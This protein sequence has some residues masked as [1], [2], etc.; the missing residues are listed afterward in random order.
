[1]DRC[2]HTVRLGT[3]KQGPERLQRTAPSQVVDK[4]KSGRSQ[5][6]Y[7]RV[8]EKAGRGGW[9]GVSQMREILSLGGEQGGFP[10]GWAISGAFVQCQAWCY[11]LDILNSPN[12]LANRSHDSP[13]QIKKSRF[14]AGG[15][16]YGFPKVIQLIHLQS[17]DSSG[18]RTACKTGGLCAPP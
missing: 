11:K 18:G 8:C 14:G 13:W 12:D 9:A 3:S 5:P 16:L 6:R 17:W 10:G 4:V 7:L 1:M 2:N 15:G